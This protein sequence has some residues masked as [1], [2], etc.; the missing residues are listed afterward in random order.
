MNCFRF[1]NT[2]DVTRVV[3]VVILAYI[4]TDFINGF[5]HMYMDNNTNYKSIVGPFIAAFHMHHKQQKYKMRNPVAIYFIE[6]GTKYWLVGY[7]GILIYLQWKISLPM[8][9]NLFLVAI[10]LLSSFAEVSHY[11]C[12]NSNKSNLVITKLQDFR[13][14]LPKYHHQNHHTKDNMNYAFL[15]GI[16]D[17]I[18]NIIAKHL[19]SGY[20]NNS[21]L[22]ALAYS[23]KQT[24]NRDY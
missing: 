19:Y 5:I 18:L 20:K 4:L 11:W 1:Y 8:Y 17:P 21:D 2:I 22:H 9:L 16:T 10:G 12:H 6:S 3:I 23:G 13:V 14:L 24:N 7:L 15:N